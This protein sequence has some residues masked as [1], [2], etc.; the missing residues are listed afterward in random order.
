MLLNFKRIGKRIQ[1][2]RELR[3]ISQMELA[4]RVDLSV[5]YIS[6]IETAKKKASLTSLIGIA[7]A[8]EVTVDVLLNGNQDNDSTEYRYDLIY[9]IEDCNSYESRFIYEISSAVKKCIRDNRDLLCKE[10]E[11][12]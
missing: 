4:E 5:P 11:L 6:Y 2:I 8:L 1:E 7:N 12:F 3:R 10:K 9:L